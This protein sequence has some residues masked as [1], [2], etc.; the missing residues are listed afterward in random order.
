MRKNR[1]RERSEKR[2]I[3][4][5]LIEKKSTKEIFSFI[6]EWNEFYNKFIKNKS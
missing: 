1:E 3:F 5:K 4:K 6:D 2:V